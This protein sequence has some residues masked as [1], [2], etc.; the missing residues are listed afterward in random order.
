M[1]NSKYL[2]KILLVHLMREGKKGKIKDSTNE[3]CCELRKLFL[4]FIICSIR[5]LSKEMFIVLSNT[6]CRQLGKN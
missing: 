1:G 2:R 5:L 3:C 4:D 6:N